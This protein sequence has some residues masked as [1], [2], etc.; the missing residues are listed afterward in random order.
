MENPYGEPL[1]R[2]PTEA[3]KLT[4]VRSGGP[5]RT[6]ENWALWA[7]AAFSV[8]G[9]LVPIYRQHGLRIFCLTLWLLAVGSA[10]VFAAAWIVEQPLLGGTGM[11][12]ICAGSIT[13]CRMAMK[14]QH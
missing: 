1:W 3:R 8:C 10:V 9:A 2:T 6:E 13:A 14:D 11:L 7:L 12:L 5:Q 4:R